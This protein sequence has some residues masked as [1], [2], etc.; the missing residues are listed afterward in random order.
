MEARYVFVEDVRDAIVA[1]H[2]MARSMNEVP[3]TTFK[4]I[5]DR[6]L[7][8][9]PKGR[10]QSS[11]IRNEMDIREKSDGKHCGLCRL[12]GHNQSKCPQ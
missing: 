3:L 1:N 4:L 10:P 6:G 5:P 7:R 9:N 2:R 12:V 8:K 11:R